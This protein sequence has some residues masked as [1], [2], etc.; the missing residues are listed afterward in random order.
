MIRPATYDEMRSAGIYDQD[1]KC[2]EKQT[3]IEG[4]AIYAG[5]IFSN[6]GGATWFVV[7]LETKQ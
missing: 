7:E 6:D 4:T 5:K 1:R 2:W 3:R